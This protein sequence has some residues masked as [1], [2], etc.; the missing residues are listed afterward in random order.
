MKLLYPSIKKI[1][2]LVVAVC[3]INAAN[4]QH[5]AYANH[6]TENKIIPNESVVKIKAR[7]ENKVVIGWAPFKGAVSHY[8]VERSINGR[9]FYEAGLLFTS[10]DWDNE[11]EYIYTDNLKV[12]YGGPLY[13]RLHVVGLDGSEIFTPVTVVN[14]GS[15]N[16]LTH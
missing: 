13:Y 15:A 8:V 4:A 6:T 14:G 2:A 11:P 3:L 9:T 16:L 1:T 10:D 12:S 7:S 5:V